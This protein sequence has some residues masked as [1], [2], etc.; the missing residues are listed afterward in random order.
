M[1]RYEDIYG[2][3]K[4]IFFAC[5]FKDAFSEDEISEFYRALNNYYD[6][7]DLGNHDPDTAVGRYDLFKI[8]NREYKYRLLSELVGSSLRDLIY[9]YDNNIKEDY[10]LRNLVTVMDII[11][12]TKEELS[13]VFNMEEKPLPKLSKDNL[14][15]YF[16][17]FLK[18]VDPSLDMYNDFIEFYEDNKRLVFLDELDEK[19]RDRV[20]GLINAEK[21]AQDSFYLCETNGNEHIYINRRGDISDFKALAHEFAHYLTCHNNMFRYQIIT[22][23]EFPSIFYETL[24]LNYLT[25]KGYS[26]E[27]IMNANINRLKNI[28][29][30]SS[31][32]GIANSYL[33][34][35]VSGGGKITEE[36]DTN[37]RREKL[38]EF[39]DNNGSEAYCELVKNNP[40]AANPETLADS[41]SGTAA[42]MFALNPNLFE[43]FYPYVI[44]NYLASN[45][46]KLLTKD[47]S[48]LEEMKDI[49]YNLPDLDI[50]SVMSNIDTLGKNK[51]YSK[52]K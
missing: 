5:L 34:L 21:V 49:T 41:Y 14:I 24:A 10:L 33:R 39:I 44:G 25:N 1:A 2:I 45:Y 26:K 23:K 9:D 46:L 11:D 12:D 52:K 40:D 28:L 19:E 50:N 29:T 42:I 38:F 8:A 3:Y 32:L 7:D 48:I 22:T 37:Y 4:K 30:Y 15:N 13:P 43:I 36:E 47:S 18:Y 20:F 35:L 16:K 17:D 51:L 6:E 27:S 31:D